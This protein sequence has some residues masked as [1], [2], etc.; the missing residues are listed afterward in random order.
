[1]YS[2]IKDEFKQTCTNCGAIFEVIASGLDGHNEPEEYFCPE[3][4]YMYKIKASLSPNVKLI[5]KRTD[6]KMDKC[7]IL[8]E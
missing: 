2:Y 6:G 8:Y 3:C 5:S 7:K 1:M 4:S